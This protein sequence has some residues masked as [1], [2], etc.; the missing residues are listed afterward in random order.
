M[1]CGLVGSYCTSGTSLAFSS[2]HCPAS[3]AFPLLSRANKTD[4]LYRIIAEIIT[5]AGTNEPVDV[6]MNE[7]TLAFYTGTRCSPFQPGLITSMYSRTHFL[8]T[9]RM[10]ML[11]LSEMQVEKLASHMRLSTAGLDLRYSMH[12][13]VLG[14]RGFVSL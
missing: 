8:E 2:C 9:E 14:A 10:E 1:S 11:V 3:L 13:P 4:S 5:D 6:V 7:N 12:K